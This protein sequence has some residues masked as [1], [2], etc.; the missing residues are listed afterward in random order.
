MNILVRLGASL[1]L[2]NGMA[3]ATVTLAPGATVDDLLGCLLDQYPTLPI[4]T[5]VPVIGG[6]SVSRTTSLFDGQEV[7]LLLPIAGG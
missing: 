6:E 5:A 3:R 2:G 4:N 7:A 1:S